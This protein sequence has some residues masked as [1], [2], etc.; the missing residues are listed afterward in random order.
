MC[1]EVYGG[2]SVATVVGTVDG[3]Q[4]DAVVDRTDACGIAR[5]DALAA[6]LPEP[7]DP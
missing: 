4:V 7:A 6:L 3:T 1:A 5:W 2:P